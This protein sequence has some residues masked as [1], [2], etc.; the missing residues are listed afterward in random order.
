[1]D[2][3]RYTELEL[4]IIGELKESIDPLIM[5]EQEQWIEFNR[6]ANFIG[7]EAEDVQNVYK[8]WQFDKIRDDMD[9]MH[10]RFNKKD[11]KDG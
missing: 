5:N 8:T 6:I 2:K 4:R 1:M 3:S 9:E 10:E 7:V 11:E